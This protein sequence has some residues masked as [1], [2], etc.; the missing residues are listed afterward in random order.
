[1]FTMIFAAALAAGQPAA[2]AD[3][4]AHHGM[5]G[6]V[7]GEMCKDCKDKAGKKMTAE[8]C[9]EC[10]K[11]MSEAEKAACMAK[12]GTKADGHGDHHQH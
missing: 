3:P 9:K 8:E 2:A 10:C 4:H 1:M 7:H 5:T 12:H 11:D 6:A